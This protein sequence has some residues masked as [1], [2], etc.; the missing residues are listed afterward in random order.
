M[1]AVSGAP[2]GATAADS[3]PF[4]HQDRW[5]R[6]LEPGV[7]PAIRRDIL[8]K[9]FL[10]AVLNQ[11][12][13]AAARVVF[14]NGEAGSGKSVLLGQLHDDLLPTH[15]AGLALLPSSELRLDDTA[16]GAG[17]MAR[18]FAEALGRPG[19]LVADFRRPER[20]PRKAL[21]L[22]TADLILTPQRAPDFVALLHD[23]RDSGVTSV[24]T[25]RKRD[26]E[27]LV[28]GELN[29]DG[30]PAIVAELPGL[31]KDEV[32]R[33]ALEY[34]A[35]Y[36]IQPPIGAERFAE[37]LLLLSDGE[38]GRTFL[39]IVSS[40]LLLSMLCQIFGDRHSGDI[41][42]TLTASDLLAG[43][44]QRTVNDSRHPD[45]RQARRLRKGA[46]CFSLAGELWR[47]SDD[48][49]CEWMSRDALERDEASALALDE[50]LS[51][52]FL[53]EDSDAPVPRIA[54]R[55]QVLTEYAIGRWMFS[56]KEGERARTELLDGLRAGSDERATSWPVARQVLTISHIQDKLPRFVRGFD[57]SDHSAFRNIAFAAAAGNAP[58][59]TRALREQ[60]EKTSREHLRVFLASLR[61][62]CPAALD[63]AWNEATH[64][65]T[66]GT[67]PAL[68]FELAT[69]LGVLAVRRPGPCA[70]AEPLRVLGSMK[71]KASSGVRDEAGTQQRSESPVFHLLQP[72]LQARRPVDLASTRVMVGQLGTTTLRE[73]YLALHLLPDTPAEQAELVQRWL[74]EVRV[75]VMLPMESSAELVARYLRWPTEEG[76]P[77]PGS[78]AQARLANL[79]L[80][81]PFDRH[82]E[83]R[84]KVAARRCAS[85]KALRR[86]LIGLLDQPLE[87]GAGER[88]IKACALLASSGHASDLAE[89]LLRERTDDSLPST[90]VTAAKQQAAVAARLLHSSTRIAEELRPALLRILR[91]SPDAPP[92]RP[93]RFVEAAAGHI[94]TCD[95]ALELI[96]GLAAD[97]RLEMIDVFLRA[98]TPE[99]V[100][101]L[102]EPLLSLID[103]AGGENDESRRDKARIP[104]YD[105]DPAGADRIADLVSLGARTHD[106]ATAKLV[107][108]YLE[109]H[110]A[111]GLITDPRSLI[112]LFG[113]PWQGIRIRA[114]RMAAEA[115]KE[116]PDRGTA[117]ADAMAERLARTVVDDGSTGWTASELQ[118]RLSL[119]DH[120]VRTAHTVPDRTAEGVCATVAEAL[121]N[122]LLGGE[123]AAAAI[124]LLRTC[125]EQGHP[126]LAR[127]APRLLLRMLSEQPIGDT[128]T[129]R[130]ALSAFAVRAV[131]R[132][133]LGLDDLTRRIPHW[134]ALTQ[135]PVVTAVLTTSPGGARGDH[136][137][138]LLRHPELSD[139]ARALIV[140]G[141]S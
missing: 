98:A 17:G 44:W 6:R 24:V 109:R 68:S 4:A 139:E 100:R 26:F 45:D 8:D 56:G 91:P 77:S 129:I 114:M 124:V 19:D 32:R 46:L 20:G 22:D 3:R 103:S 65:L 134:P 72:L 95:E 138:A 29:S 47:E 87:T 90:R 28:R 60:A 14:V 39:E 119:L 9:R 99:T 81:G 30:R 50:L 102:R 89:H 120:S 125:F 83:L 31:T 135:A 76:E 40:P 137:T 11:R 13:G 41:P 141:R 113:R 38:A 118:A 140:R 43:Y 55:H 54:F 61:G 88:V 36:G 52:G 37:S 73:Q 82:P 18:A 21:L 75:G 108:T 48:T 126:G 96:G 86:T 15:G 71:V 116:H 123:P 117:R 80:D 57:L 69:V 64:L 136:A 79:L 115:L 35:R 42:P 132:G 110:R 12:D 122:Q 92:D 51:E 10:P 85:S 107:C 112:P 70:I 16:P 1:N 53:V 93:R 74:L 101:A 27:T 62:S 5:R 33:F 127:D 94:L 105:A 128:R 106:L 34:L 78:A 111:T 66:S 49:L 25:C 58:A 63:T 7:F 133:A 130:Q 59:V 121:D 104:V 23:L 97:K 84:A 2:G 67:E 131:N